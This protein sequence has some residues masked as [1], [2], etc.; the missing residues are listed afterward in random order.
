MQKYDKFEERSL[1][2]EKVAEEGVVLLKNEDN[3]LPLE[4]KKVA[5]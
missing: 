5:V 1:L 4:N 3:S 2:T